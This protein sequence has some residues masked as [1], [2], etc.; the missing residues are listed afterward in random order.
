M[1]LHFI[2][3]PVQLV[4]DFPESGKDFIHAL[5]RHDF[6]YGR[7]QRRH[8]GL[9]DFVVNLKHYCKRNPFFS[10]YLILKLDLLRLLDGQPFCTSE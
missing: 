7:L 9:E 10:G 8:H 2:F 5:Y 6:A 4:G 3:L 1:T